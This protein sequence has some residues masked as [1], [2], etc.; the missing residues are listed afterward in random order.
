MS[1]TSTIKKH[2][3]IKKHF[4]DADNYKLD[5][6]DHLSDKLVIA[7]CTD[8]HLIVIFDKL[9]YQLYSNYF[10]PFYNSVETTFQGNQGRANI[11][12]KH[13]S[14]YRFMGKDIIADDKIRDHLNQKN[15]IKA[16][17]LVNNASL[18]KS[19]DRINFMKEQ[20]SLD[21]EANVEGSFIDPNSGKIGEL[22]VTLD[23][24]Y[25][26]EIRKL[27][28]KYFIR[29]TDGT[30]SVA[31]NNVTV[32]FRDPSDKPSWAIWFLD[33]VPL[34]EIPNPSHLF[35]LSD[36]EKAKFEPTKLL[37]N[38]IICHASLW[39]INKNITGILLHT[40]WNHIS[41]T[42]RWKVEKPIEIASILFRLCG[43]PA[44]LARNFGYNP[45]LSF[46]G[47]DWF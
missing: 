39:V 24:S 14:A 20:L 34:V 36:E 2:I 27:Q 3:T 37:D 30:Y 19:T 35:F 23:S 10:S 40:S 4:D 26:T 5:S 38:P 21:G 42:Y 15:Y 29:L 13:M 32:K 44:H 8:E 6:L 1:P 11:S 45:K 18:I 12:E 41:A 28:E 31:S 43:H 33:A 16:V 7:K 9:V 22:I 25:Q 46:P 47:T 17:S